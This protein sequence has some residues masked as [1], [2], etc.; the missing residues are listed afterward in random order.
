M[1]SP[2]AQA[3]PFV[4]T[5]PFRVRAYEVG[6]DERARVLA[7]CDYV[8]EAAGE[9]AASAGVETFALP[10]GDAG[11]WVLAR[12]RFEIAGRPAMRS[13]VRVV[14]WPA[15]QD[16]L[17]AERDFEL[18]DD[19]DAVLMRGTSTWVVMSV[20]RRR[21]VRLPAAIEA[22]GPA[23]RA[24]ALPPPAAE[25]AAPEVGT[26]EARFT[27]RT[28]D[29]D[30]VGHANNVRF[31]EWALEAAERLSPG[32]LAGLDLAF[33]AE[34]VAGDVIVSTVGPGGA[35]GT[36]AHRLARESDD[37]PLALATSVWT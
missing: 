33:R 1:P 32:T 8:Q 27:V 30:R 26:A 35:P 7:L 34:A 28:S 21:P 37:R 15:A 25:P 9:H 3:D 5:E 18:L 12:L 22:F 31:A 10:G 13:R 24:R 14:T 17:R 16:G 2:P 11:T 29:L 23:D 20:A 19:A 4:W 6:P 36:L